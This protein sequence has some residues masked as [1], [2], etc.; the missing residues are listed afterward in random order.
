VSSRHPASVEHVTDCPPVREERCG[1]FLQ[2]G[3]VG[4]IAQQVAGHPL[5]RSI[6]GVDL[7]ECDPQ[8]FFR[9]VERSPRGGIRRRVVRSPVTG[10]RLEETPL[11]GKVAVHGQALHT[12]AFCDRA[13]RR[14][15][16]T[17]RVMELDRRLD[18]PLPRRGE[19]LCSLF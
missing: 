6:E 19:A 1:D 9:V 7:D 14:P 10:A 11:V 3:R 16:R 15:G 5:G 18:D 8:P 17:E 2:H 4:E 12:G 13:D